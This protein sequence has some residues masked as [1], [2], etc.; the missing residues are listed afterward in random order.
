MKIV[1][2]DRR[3]EAYR[4][5][6]TYAIRWPLYDFSKCRKYEQA[7]SDLYGWRGFCVGKSEWYSGFGSRDRASGRKAYFIYVRNQSVITAV[8]MKVMA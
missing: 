3:Y 7:L 1:K 5:G 8:L 6:Y 4:E 2:L